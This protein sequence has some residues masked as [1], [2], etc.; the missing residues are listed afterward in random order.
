M[1]QMIAIVIPARTV[2]QAIIGAGIRVRYDGRCGDQTIS[3]YIQ[4]LNRI[5]GRVNVS[6]GSSDN[7]RLTG[8]ALDVQQAQNITRDFAGRFAQYQRPSGPAPAPDEPQEAVPIAFD[9][10]INWSIAGTAL[11]ILGAV[12]ALYYFTQD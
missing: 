8:E 7:V 1:A 9:S 12:G 11:L 2:Q 10:G 4:F 6:C 3:A 5:G